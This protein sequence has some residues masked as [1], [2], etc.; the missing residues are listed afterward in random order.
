MYW[1]L[2][3]L[4]KYAVFRGRARRKEFWMFQLVNTGVLFILAFIFGLFILPTMI[5]YGRSPLAGFLGLVLISYVLAMLIPSL[6]VSVRRLHDTNL[7]GWWLLI[8]LIPLGG[9]VLFVFHLLDSTPGPNQYGPNPKSIGP[10]PYATQGLTFD[11]QAMAVAATADAPQQSSQWFPGSCNVCGTQMQA[12]M[13]FCPK[14][15]KAA[16]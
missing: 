11:T 1:Y 7:S 16:F 14:C 12:G 10:A 8:G 9:I 5:K 15:G 4:K 13:R 6:A 2:E 3:V